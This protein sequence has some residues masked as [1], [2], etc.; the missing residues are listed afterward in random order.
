[1]KEIKK[2][3]ILS[4]FFI[5]L[6]FSADIIDNELT[7]LDEI[8]GR[9]YRTYKR[10]NELLTDNTKF[11]IDT[12]SVLY[13][14]DLYFGRESR[15]VSFEENELSR[16]YITIWYTPESSVYK[17]SHSGSDFRKFIIPLD[18]ALKKDKAKIVTWLE[19]KH[20]INKLKHR[21]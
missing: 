9:D 2:L 12:L 6:I 20:K 14:E 10:I 17:S 3:L 1:M 21:K 7:E 5:I 15:F 19:R 11:I 16:F 4:G 8:G 13:P 18:I